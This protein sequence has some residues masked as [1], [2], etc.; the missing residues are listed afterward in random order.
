VP[1]LSADDFTLAFVKRTARAQAVTGRY[2][3]L[4][5]DGTRYTAADMRRL[6]HAANVQHREAGRRDRSAPT[7]TSEDKQARMLANMPTQALIQL[8]LLVRKELMSRTA[9]YRDLERHDVG[10]RKTV[11]LEEIAEITYKPETADIYILRSGSDQSVGR[12]TR[13]P[14]SKYGFGVTLRPDASVSVDELFA[15]LTDL[16]RRGAFR[17]EARGS[18]PLVHLPMRALK[19][20]RIEVRDTAPARSSLAINRSKLMQNPFE[21]PTAPEKAKPVR[22]LKEVAEVTYEPAAADIYVMLSGPVESVGRPTHTPPS[23]FGAAIV[24]G[25]T[26]RPGAP[27][28]VKQ[29][30][31]QLT[32]AWRSGRLSKAA[33]GAR[34]I[35]HLSREALEELEVRVTGTGAP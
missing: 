15:L 30:F 29:I 9:V 35:V 21:A 32:T 7:F 16:W 34:K 20:F 3:P 18:T 4:H 24:A 23:K 10:P 33:Q 12:P 28:S 27:I 17:R 8:Q 13:T 25:V 26:L 19:A 31:A 2:R 22:K 5:V 14:L 6:A 11:R 1:K